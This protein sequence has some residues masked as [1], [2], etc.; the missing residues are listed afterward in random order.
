MRAGQDFDSKIPVKLTPFFS[1]FVS[2]SDEI[3]SC[4]HASEDSFVH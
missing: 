4:G 1:L 2:V 3:L